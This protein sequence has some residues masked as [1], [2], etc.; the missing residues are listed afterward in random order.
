VRIIKGRF[1]AR[2]F[3]YRL[4]PSFVADRAAHR[5]QRE[6]RDRRARRVL[7]EAE[8]AGNVRYTRKVVAACKGESARCL[9]TI[10]PAELTEL[11]KSGDKLSGNFFF[12][13]RPTRGHSAVRWGSGDH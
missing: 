4:G 6:A 13:V 11:T 1:Y 10:A 2:V 5:R 3:A 7:L 12:G 8:A 9:H